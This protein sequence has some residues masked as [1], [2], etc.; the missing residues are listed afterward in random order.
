MTM[1]N[2]VVPPAAAGS[3]DRE[4]PPNL[5]ARLLS[6]QQELTAVER[7]S[8]LQDGGDSPS[9]ARRY[10]SLLPAAPPRAGE[11]YA[12]EVDLDACSGCKAC[13]TACHSLNGL[14]D[15]ETWRDVGLLHG[16]TDALPVLQHVTSACHHC[17]DPA[18]MNV[19]PVDAYEKD[20]QTGIVKHLDDQCFGCQYCTL[21]C[22]YE[23]PKY[24]HAKG[25]VRKCDMCS[26][27]L[28]VGEAPACVQACPHEAIR[29]RTVTVD[30]VIADCETNLFLPGAPE[31][32]YTLPTTTYK[33]NRV[34]PRNT[35]P[36]DYF[37][38]KPEHAHWPLVLMLVLTQLSVGA[39]LVEL[40]LHNLL[41]GRLPDSIRAVHS[42]SAALFGLLA[43]A[44]STCHLGRPQY[45]YRAIL[46]LRH[47]WLSREIVAFGVF[48][49]LSVAYALAK[50]W[51]P[52][53]D[54]IA[55][56]VHVLGTAVVAT[57]LAGVVCSIMIYQCT[58]RDFWNGAATTTKFL[59][60]TVILGLATALLTSL[61]VQLGTDSAAVRASLA[62][63]APGLCRLLIAATAFKLLFEASIFRRLRDRQNTPMKRSALLLCGELATF[64]QVRFAFG[65]LGG[66]VLPAWL[67]AAAVFS[68]QSEIGDLGLGLAVAAS[69]ALLLIG[70]LLERM[71]FFT[72]VVAPKMPGG[73]PS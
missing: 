15:A 65:G 26:Q 43:L 13:V 56:H 8:Q 21:A 47:S 37:S 30:D 51:T 6:E 1:L 40:I 55:A 32:H 57:G 45:A 5:L 54:R 24:N 19:C 49:A 67:L 52:I 68:P 10:S 7:F 22:P 64:T 50:W 28:A 41:G 73:L 48:A 53:G 25:I 27:R 36:A 42:L 16:G 72:A 14:D 46:G 58:R 2:I 59:S 61:L 39:F 23:V 9:Q 4:P 38:A 66:V 60:T 17:L 62:E 31:P 69:F 3:P 20:P 11:Q 70:E 18:C 34:F 12:F 29:I 44:A 63:Y 35:L 33:S 71:L